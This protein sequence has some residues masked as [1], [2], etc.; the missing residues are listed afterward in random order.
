ML[1]AQL[2]TDAALREDSNSSD[3]NHRIAP[4]LLDAS[5]RL[6]HF[7]VGRCQFPEER[8]RKKEKK[9]EDNLQRTYVLFS[10]LRIYNEYSVTLLSDL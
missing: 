7:D 6:R 2:A 5:C 10:P 3:R 8:E 1:S 4:G 9:E